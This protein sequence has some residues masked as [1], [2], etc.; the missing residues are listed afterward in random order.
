MVWLVNVLDAVGIINV[1]LGVGG[2]PPTAGAAKGA[3]STARVW[4]SKEGL[5]PVA[6]SIK[7][8]IFVDSETDIAGAQFKLAYDASELK[9]GIPQLT[10]R[11]AHMALASGAKDGE[12]A[13]VLYRLEGKVIPTGSGSVLIVPFKISDIRYHMSDTRLQPEEVILASSGC[14]AIPAE[15]EPIVVKTVPLPTE[16]ALA[17]N[18]PNPF[19]PTTHI[20][21]T[22]PVTGEWG[23]VSGPIHTTLKIYNLLGQEVRTLVDRPK[24]PGYHTVRSVELFAIPSALSSHMLG[25]DLA[26]SAHPLHMFRSW[27]RSITPAPAWGSWSDLRL[28]QIPR[29]DG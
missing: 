23:L 27:G 9:P 18:Y 11:S 19:N 25:Q 14:Q 13:V 26:T 1:V 22:L 4:S 29:F 20:H 8:P 7:V 5:E 2:C 21:F 12:L 24:D 6:M 10:E 28:K 3:V 15:I 17:Q 16:L